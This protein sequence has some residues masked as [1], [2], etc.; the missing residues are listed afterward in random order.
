MQAT[1]RC[2]LESLATFA[3]FETTLYSWKANR[4]VSS[5][6]HVV[7]VITV[8]VWYCGCYSIVVI[9]VVAAALGVHYTAVAVVLPCRAA[10]PFTMSLHSRIARRSFFPLN[11]LS[12]A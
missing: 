3:G 2:E 7:I 5:S 10:R 12:F 6:S 8:V 11:V 4:V 1:V 9:I